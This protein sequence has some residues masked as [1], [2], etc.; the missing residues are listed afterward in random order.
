VAAERLADEIGAGVPEEDD[1]EQ[2]IEKE[3]PGLEPDP[4]EEIQ[5]EAHI[6]GPDHGDGEGGRKAAELLHGVGRDDV[7]D[8]GN[9]KDGEERRLER[10]GA[11]DRR[12]GWMRGSA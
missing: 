12:A 1:G 11:E 4:V 3:R 2:K 8:G 6:E 9:E 5:G 10:D 7:I